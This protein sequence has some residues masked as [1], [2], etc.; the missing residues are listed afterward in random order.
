MVKDD[1]STDRE[2]Q[3][4]AP[5]SNPVERV[6]RRFDSWQQRHTII[7]FPIAVIKKFGGDVGGGNGW[8]CRPPS[9]CTPSRL[10]SFARHLWPRNV[11]QPPLTDADKARY[12]YALRAEAHRPE[13]RLHIAY[14][15]KSNVGG[16]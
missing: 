3:S 4:D 7:G 14:K 5:S 16:G 9:S 8:R 11:V 6:V 12:T 10:T 15:A 1:G 2:P 13:Q